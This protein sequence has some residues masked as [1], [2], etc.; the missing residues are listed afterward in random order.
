MQNNIVVILDRLEQPTSVEYVV[1]SRKRQSW[2]TKVL[3]SNASLNETDSGSLG[4]LMPQSDENEAPRKRANSFGRENEFVAES[5]PV[6]RQS[7]VWRQPRGQSLSL[8]SSRP[9]YLVKTSQDQS[10]RLSFSESLVLESLAE[11]AARKAESS[12]GRLSMETRA[13]DHLRSSTSD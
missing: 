9:S 3:L 12:T 5:K 11:N 8:P 2:S 4:Y 10:N 7:I 13:E 6:F 1:D